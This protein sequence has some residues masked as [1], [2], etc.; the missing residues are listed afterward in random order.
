MATTQAVVGATPAQGS[1]DVYPI[2]FAVGVSR[3][4]HQRR[5]AFFDACDR[6][7]K[8]ASLVTGGTA[9][10]AL[11]AN[12]P[13]YAQWAALSV[14]ILSAADV[15]VSLS[16]SARKHEL[17]YRQF[18]D[19]LEEINRHRVPTDDDVA[20]WNAQRVKIESEEPPINGALADVCYNEEARSRGKTKEVPL[21]WYQ[22]LFMHFVDLPPWQR[23]PKTVNTPP[24]QP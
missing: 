13:Q 8:I 20:R 18:N 2:G 17:L 21:Y 10:V 9:F 11:V 4:Y 23:P 16:T 14:A 7:V 15:V 22:I 24:S 12:E 3:R 1:P 5:R 19:L 6:L